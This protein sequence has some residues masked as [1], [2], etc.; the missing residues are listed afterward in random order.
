LPNEAAIGSLDLEWNWLVGE[1][2]YN[3]NAKNVHW[4]LGGP[5]FKEYNNSDYADEWFKLYA[6]TI[7]V[8]L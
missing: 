6:D 2:E 1:Y 8:E 7:K 4:T 3:E 5:Y